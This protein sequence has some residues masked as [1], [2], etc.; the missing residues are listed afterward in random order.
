MN[1]IDAEKLK[2]KIRKHLI[3]TILDRDYDEWEKGKDAGLQQAIGIVESLQQEQLELPTIKGWI[4]R[5]DAD[6]L[7]LY[8]QKPTR[9]TELGAFS[10][11]V[12]SWVIGD[13]WIGRF[14]L[15]QTARTLFPNLC[16]TD[17]PMEVELMFKPIQEQ[18]EVDLE[19]EIRDYFS[20]WDYDFYNR[21]ITMDNDT[22]ATLLSIQNVARHFWK[23][24]YNARKEE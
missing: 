8:D 7:G 16:W 23:K 3:P 2:A 9:K 24:G 6:R 14:S 4:A 21:V 13:T 22:V 19:K 18:P 1:Y 10:G 11:T 15:D 12:H 17:D 5:D 20:K